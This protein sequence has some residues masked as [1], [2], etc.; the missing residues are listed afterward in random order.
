MSK[1]FKV[2][3]FVAALCGT[4]AIFGAGCFPN[5]GT[6]AFLF[7]TLGAILQEELLG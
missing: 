4:V 3:A 5:L 7:S 2:C 1:R 6:G